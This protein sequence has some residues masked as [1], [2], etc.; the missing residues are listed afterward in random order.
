MRGKRGLA[1]LLVLCCMLPGCAGADYAETVRIEV[2]AAQW[3]GN[4]AMGGLSPEAGA[5]LAEL[6]GALVLEVRGVTRTDGTQAM[7]TCTLTLYGEEL[8]SLRF[9]Q[10][11]DGVALSG[12]LLPSGW[13]VFSDEMDLAVL[14]M[15]PGQPLTLAQGVLALEQ[16]AEEIQA[17][18]DAQTLAQLCEVLAGWH[19]AYPAARVAADASAGLGAHDA[20]AV[21]WR[22]E[23][24][25]QAAIAL[26]GALLEAVL[27]TPSAQAIMAQE[28]RAWDEE[29]NAYMQATGE[30]LEIP[31]VA[32]EM[33]W[34]MR[35]LKREVGI[36]L[37][38]MAQPLTLQTWQGADG[39]LV[40]G[41]FS[42][43]LDA[44]GTIA[45]RGDYRRLTEA[46]DGTLHT[47][48]AS[49]TDALE[50][51]VRAELALRTDAGRD[52]GQAAARVAHALEGQV[53]LYEAWMRQ[54]VDVTGA[55]TGPAAGAEDMRR[56]AWLRL[57]TRG[58]HLPF[59]DVALEWV[60]H[61]NRP[62][63]MRALDTDTQESFSAYVTLPGTDGAPARAGVTLDVA[64]SVQKASVGLAP[65]NARLVWLAD[66]DDAAYEAFYRDVEAR[67]LQAVARVGMKM[68]TALRTPIMEWLGY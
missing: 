18:G 40:A 36:A 28:Q 42:S 63:P 53:R 26:S 49:L 57:T 65:P 23:L 17:A 5:Q 56:E 29:Y 52:A 2:A 20:A 38:G 37:Y 16:F 31:S 41:A 60:S 67:L 8:V 1:W 47:V 68:P 7:T 58:K 35:E 9:W 45:L 32:E 50:N 48:T 19:G 44:E 27:V 3:P 54:T 22:Y 34:W 10:R 12:S 24:S 46:Q 15:V 51:G 4:L 30:Q 25:S 62:G 21:A 33:D 13:Y 14:G 61:P 6:L 43:L 55:Y 11:E 59:S 66:M 64:V 39:A